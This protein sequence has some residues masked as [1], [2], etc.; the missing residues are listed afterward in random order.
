MATLG[1]IKV[2]PN[3]RHTPYTVYLD[4]FR[5]HFSE[6]GNGTPA[7]PWTLVESTSSLFPLDGC[8]IHHLVELLV[9]M[10]NGK[11]DQNGTN[12]LGNTGTS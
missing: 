11:W 4:I 6:S 12:H 10:K 5:G 9:T 8:E 7:S 1:G 3:L 2:Y